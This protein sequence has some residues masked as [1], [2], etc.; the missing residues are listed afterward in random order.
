MIAIRMQ[1]HMVHESAHQF[2]GF[3]R[4]FLSQRIYEV[5]NLLAM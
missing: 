2:A 3:S 1:H 4:V 5:G